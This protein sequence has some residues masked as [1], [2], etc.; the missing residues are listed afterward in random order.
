MPEKALVISKDYYASIGV[1]VKSLASAKKGEKYN[2]RIID[3]FSE[4]IE[5]DK[6]PCELELVHIEK[7]YDKRK[8]GETKNCEDKEWDIYEVAK[9]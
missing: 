2:G 6:N 9:K 8:T 3:E 1:N 4:Y 7:P 5:L